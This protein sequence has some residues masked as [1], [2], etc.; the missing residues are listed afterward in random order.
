MAQRS[1]KRIKL[2]PMLTYAATQS[3]GEFSRC[4]QEY[5]T[6]KGT[7]ARMCLEESRQGALAFCKIGGATKEFEVMDKVYTKATQGRTFVMVS[8]TSNENTRFEVWNGMLKGQMDRYRREYEAQQIPDVPSREESPSQWMLN[9]WMYAESWMTLQERDGHWH[10]QR[11]INKVYLAWPWHR[12]EALETFERL[13]VRY[14][15]PYMCDAWST[16]RKQPLHWDMVVKHQS[17]LNRQHLASCMRMRTEDDLHQYA[18]LW[19]SP[20]DYLL[21]I[22]HRDD[23]PTRE[24][25]EAWCTKYN[26]VLNV[27]TLGVI[28]TSTKFEYSSTTIQ[29]LVK[30]GYLPVVQGTEDDPFFYFDYYLRRWGI[31]T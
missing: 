3:L 15:I 31:R 27:E 20:E 21:H 1:R 12:H 9:K 14:G 30:F 16:L 23:D 2:D 29:L 10:I 7:V 19:S 18:P 28:F 13:L 25:V 24:L 4:I 5:Q 6:R 17:T 22:L 26:H 11:M 8:N